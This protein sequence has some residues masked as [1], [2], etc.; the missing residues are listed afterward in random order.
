MIRKCLYFLVFVLA[1]F[2][3]IAQD[4]INPNGYTIFYYPNGMKSSEGNLVNGQPDGWWKSYNTEGTM[5]SEGNRKNFQLDSLWVFYNDKGEKTL[6]IHYTEG[7]KNGLR[8]Q[9]Y[10]D[11]FTVENWKMDTLKGAV[12][13]YYTDSTIK[14]YTPYEEGKPHGLEKE[15]NQDGVVTAITNFYRGVM[16]RR[17]FI[18]RTDNFGYKQGNWKFFWDNGNLQMEGTY[19]NDKKNGFFKYYDE[20]GNFLNVEK[21]ENDKL[22][23]DAPEIKVLDKKTA[24]HSNGQPSITATYYKGVPEGIRREFDST[25][26]VVK[27]YIF[28]NGIMRYE[29]VTD[30]NGKREGPWKEYYLTGE[31]KAEGRYRNSLPV[32]DWK[33]YFMDKSI[34]IIGSYNNRGQKIGE[35]QWFYP[36][37]NLLIVENYDNGELDGEYIEYDEEGNILTKGQYVIGEEDGPWTYRNGGMVEKGS[38]YDGMRQGTWKL[39]Y[40]N[41]KLASEIEFDQDLPNGKFIT[42]W[43]NGNTKETGKYIT[44]EK[45]GLWNKYD[46]EGTLFLTTQYREG[47]EIRWNA[48]K[49]DNRP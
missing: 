11:E 47:R 8:I 39:W 28:E 24:Y 44:G 19:Q 49:I 2:S 31:L 40:A 37:G 42:Y 43:E 32:G 48:Y 22:I 46:E 35:W 5:V 26:K 33:F 17:E 7:K 25:G 36:N 6:E 29:G 3:L 38:Y 23:E 30:L 27:G 21:Y 10:P 14:K 13:T 41:G 16:T 34:E 9:Y 1:G 20:E 45:T 15:F 18:N 4:K 12:I